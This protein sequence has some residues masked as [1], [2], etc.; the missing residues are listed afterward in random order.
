MKTQLLSLL[1]LISIL[2]LSGCKLGKS[3]SKGSQNLNVVL[4]QQENMTKFKVA[5]A[6][7]FQRRNHRPKILE[8]I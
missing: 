3:K 1:V 5:D 2:I 4:E 7:F 8:E 6:D